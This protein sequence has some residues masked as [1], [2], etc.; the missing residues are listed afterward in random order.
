MT[1]TIQYN[2]VERIANKT[3][4]LFAVPVVLLTKEKG[5]VAVEENGVS[6]PYKFIEIVID[7]N[8]YYVRNKKATLKKFNEMTTHEFKGTFAH[9]IIFYLKL[10]STFFPTNEVMMATTI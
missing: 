2:F 7:G 3:T 9:W 4:A 5:V 1:S 8:V 10:N 6:L